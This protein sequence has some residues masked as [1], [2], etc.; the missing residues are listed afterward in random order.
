ML[1]GVILCC[2]VAMKAAAEMQQSSLRACVL[3]GSAVG[4]NIAQE[5]SGR[6][7]MAMFA[8]VLSYSLLCRMRVCYV[9]L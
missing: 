1:G 4:S 9:I 6:M 5:E 7:H 2:A 3:F 8:S